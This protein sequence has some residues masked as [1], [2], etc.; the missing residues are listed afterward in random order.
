MH[1][2][3]LR[4]N[5]SALLSILGFAAIFLEQA[6][7]YQPLINMLNHYMQFSRWVINHIGME[8]GGLCSPFVSPHYIFKFKSSMSS[9]LSHCYSSASFERKGGKKHWLPLLGFWLV[10]LNVYAEPG[11]KN[12]CWVQY[13]CRHSPPK[14]NKIHNKLCRRALSFFVQVKLPGAAATFSND[15][16]GYMNYAFFIH[17]HPHSIVCWGH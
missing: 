15:F 14:I 3:A 7:R 4:S 17:I 12:R 10:T 1:N 9:F 2:A 6:P 5:W 16:G 13:S 11:K 8:A